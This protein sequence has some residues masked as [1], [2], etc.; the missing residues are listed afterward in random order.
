MG[1]AFD[2][3]LA[4]VKDR[5]GQSDAEAVAQAVRA[6]LRTLGSHLGGVPPAL[7]DALPRGLRPELTAG[8]GTEAV[9]PAELYQLLAEQL[10]VRVGVALEL[11]QST[12]AELAESLL[13][14]AAEQLRASLPPTWAALVPT[15][16]DLSHE[17]SRPMQAAKL[18][19]G[20]GAHKLTEGSGA[21]KLTEG[22]GAHKLTEGSGAHKLT[23]SS[24]MHRLAEG[25]GM[26]KLAEGSGMHKLTE[27]SGMHK[28]TEGS[29]MHRLASSQSGSS[30]PL[31]DTR[32]PTG[33]AY[34]LRP[35]ASTRIGEVL[36]DEGQVQ[37][38]LEH[39]ERAYALQAETETDPSLAG[40][41]CFVLARARWA[42]GQH[43][44]ARTVARAAAEAYAAVPD[45]EHEAE[46]RRWLAEHGEV[47]K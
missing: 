17:A 12:M 26:H 21:H 22:S 13:H 27:G 40:D 45:G 10:G 34:S 11:V 29:G 8:A 39:L 16:D 1:H 44:P 37:A 30:R 18:T 20:S 24:G 38:A 14:P 3:F 4:R 5:A 9:R 41:T 19:E 31:A 33:Q 36:L 35:N 25:S 47:G 42:A 32:P 23:E 7:H 28:L 2:G 6:T 46:I 15:A 43:E